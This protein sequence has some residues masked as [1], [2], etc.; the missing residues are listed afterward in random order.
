MTK[1]SI[2][3][4]AISIFLALLSALLVC[5][6]LVSAWS[7]PKMETS[8]TRSFR[9]SGQLVSLDKLFKAVESSALETTLVQCLIS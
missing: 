4:N 9:E 8:E 6:F 1:E 5:S 7:P 3:R 2:L